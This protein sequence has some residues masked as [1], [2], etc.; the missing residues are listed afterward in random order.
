ML[1][2]DRVVL[3]PIQASDHER[4]YE[5]VETIEVRSLSSNDPPVPLSFEQFKARYEA[6]EEE[7]AGA[8]FVVEVDGEVVGEC[9]LHSIEHYQ[10]RAEVGI[11]L[12]KEYWGRG[13]G[14]DAVRTLLGYAFRTLNLEKISL[15]VI[16]GDER[17]VGAYRKAGFVEEGRLRSHLWYDGTR[18]DEL[19]MSVLRDDWKG[20]PSA[21][22]APEGPASTS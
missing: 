18:Q 11:S 14:Q 12:G 19:V 5:L 9:G 6:A 4:L 13:Y 17:A 8:W 2:G 3:R 16:A 22:E 1:R 7:A 10:Q 20:D 21:S 15:H